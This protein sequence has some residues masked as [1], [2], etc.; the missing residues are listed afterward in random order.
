MTWLVSYSF[1]EDVLQESCG[2]QAAPGQ[3]E[4]P[5]CTQFSLWGNHFQQ[6]RLWWGGWSSIEEQGKHVE[7]HWVELL[8]QWRWM[9][10]FS[11]ES[12]PMGE[13]WPYRLCALWEDHSWLGWVWNK[14]EGARLPL[15]TFS[16]NDNEIKKG[17]LQWPGEGEE[18]MDLRVFWESKDE[19]L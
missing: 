11:T 14:G 5:F 16:D 4:K 13:D 2:D 9:R 17:Q 19:T 8:I 7:P 18:E 6:G 15:G 12:R 10:L 3:K 1:P